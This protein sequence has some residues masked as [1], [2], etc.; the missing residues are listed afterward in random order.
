MHEGSLESGNRE[1]KNVRFIS[2]LY[3]ILLA[4]AIRGFIDWTRVRM[5]ASTEMQPA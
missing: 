5:K 2:L 3:V 1:L 4:L